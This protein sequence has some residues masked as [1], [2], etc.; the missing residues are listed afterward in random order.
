[1][2]SKK[3]LFVCTGNTCRSP[4]AEGLARLYF[5]EGVEIFSAGIQALDGDPVSP[6]AGQILQERG[7]DSRQ[8]RAARLQKDTLAAAGL[9]LTM[10]KAQKKLLVSIYPEYQDKIMQLGEWA[11]LDKEISDPWLGSLETYRLCAEEIEETIKAGI[12]RYQE[13]S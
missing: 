9:I 5:P 12:R 2:I 4:M 6:Y 10:T 3:I 8:H 7:I 11:G 13:K 1:M